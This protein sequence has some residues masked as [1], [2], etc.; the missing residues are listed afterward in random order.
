MEDGLIGG[1]VSGAD[2]GVGFP[3]DGEEDAA[4]FSFWDDECVVGS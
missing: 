2:D 1:D 3:G 4:V